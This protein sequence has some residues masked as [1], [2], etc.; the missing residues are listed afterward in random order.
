[1]CTNFCGHG[2]TYDCNK[3]LQSLGV[4]RTRTIHLPIYRVNI[5]CYGVIS[6]PLYPSVCLYVS[7]CLCL[8]RQMS[9]ILSLYVNLHLS[10]SLSFFQYQK[11]QMLDFIV[12]LEFQWHQRCHFILVG[13]LV[14]LCHQFRCSRRCLKIFFASFILLHGPLHLFE[15]YHITII[16]ITITF[17]CLRR[18]SLNTM[19]GT[20]SILPPFD[21]FTANL[22]LSGLPT[23]E[24]ATYSCPWVNT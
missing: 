9:V 16:I 21:F 2:C 23:L 7:F 17:Y 12:I 15:Y 1:M 8:Y 6:L 5:W 4:I 10:I 24:H 20:S 19:F 22:S 14:V 11:T 18:T 3:F 13:I